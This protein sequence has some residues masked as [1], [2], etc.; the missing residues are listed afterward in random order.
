MLDKARNKHNQ[1]SLSLHSACNAITRAYRS[2]LDQFDIT[3]PQYLVLLALW[4]ADS[5][6]VKELSHQTL[7]DSS[8]LT[9]LLK[10]LEAK[11]LITR[12]RRRDDERVR[13]ICLTREGR[14]LER[15]ASDVPINIRRRIGLSVQDE[16]ELQ[17]YCQRITDRLAT[18]K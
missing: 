14:A 13:V 12:S 7:L 18:P 15:S 1:L 11:D 10:R 8:T 6:S 5:V 9:P 3:Y 17:L 16:A 4:H 2:T